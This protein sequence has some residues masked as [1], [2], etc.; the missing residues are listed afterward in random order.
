MF[1]DNFLYLLYLLLKATVLVS[2]SYRKLVYNTLMQNVLV[3]YNIN[4][5]KS[6]KKKLY[7]L[8]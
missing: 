6:L 2:M 1:L 4:I 8:F 5:T 7:S 3:L